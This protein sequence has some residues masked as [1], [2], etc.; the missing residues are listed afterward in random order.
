ME[1][2]IVK[3]TIKSLTVPKILPVEY[4]PPIPAPHTRT[5]TSVNR[6]VRIVPN[7]AV[8]PQQRLDFAYDHQ[9]RRI[10]KRVWNNTTG[11][12]ALAVDQK[13][14]Y[15]GWNLVAEL[16]A[17]NNTVVRSH[18]W[19]LDLSG[20][21]QGAG[22]VGGLLWLRDT[23]TLN[24]QPSTHFVAHDGNGNVSLLVN[25]ADGTDSAR[26]EY[27]PLEEVIRQTG[28]MAKANPFRF[29]TKYQDEETELLY[30]GYR[31]YNPSM[32]MWLSEDPVG[33]SGFELARGGGA[34]SLFLEDAGNQ[35]LFVHNEP[36][37]RYDVLGL[38]GNPLCGAYG[39][40]EPPFLPPS[41]TCCCKVKTMPK[42]EIET[43]I[44]KLHWRSPSPDPGRIDGAHPMHRWLAWP[45]G[46]VDANAINFSSGRI[47]IGGRVFSPAAAESLE[48]MRPADRFPLKLSPC[49]YDFKKLINCVAAKA[50]AAASRGQ[51]NGPAPQCQT[52][53]EGIIRDCMNSSK[54]CTEP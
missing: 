3:G 40:I 29:S 46:S 12:G 33:E 44:V 21:L 28:P 25:A 53:V 48:W 14:L 11:T 19:G 4:P 5:G 6:L 30:Y 26:Y 39:C 20:S 50:T 18:V 22:G 32:G 36:I 52:F 51:Y 43:G 24:N 47:E 45:G 35:Y 49:R 42:A 23:S 31:Y 10:T 41:G 13:F 2:E 9:G 34:N 7:T 16:N 37:D 8:G 17:T 15:D 1:H 27:G 54:G 38:L